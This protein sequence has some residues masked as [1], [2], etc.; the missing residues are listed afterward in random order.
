VGQK[1]T[2]PEYVPDDIR[3][4]PLAWFGILAPPQL[5]QAQD[6]FSQALDGLA[7]A[8]SAQVKLLELVN[9]CSALLQRKRQ[10]Q[11]KTATSDSEVKALEQ[12]DSDNIM[13]NDGKTKSAV[14]GDG[15][16]HAAVEDDFE[17]LQ[18]DD[19]DDDAGGGS[20]DKS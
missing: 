7:D 11:Q 9:R 8:A 14:D 15:D 4:K 19:D 3:S 20:N 1:R 10:L 2:I 6:D 13:N 18:L 12:K 17:E 16:D 5:R